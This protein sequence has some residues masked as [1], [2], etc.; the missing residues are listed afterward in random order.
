MTIQELLDTDFAEHDIGQ[1]TLQR[2]W[3]LAR[4]T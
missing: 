4:P 1:E 3:E 2:N